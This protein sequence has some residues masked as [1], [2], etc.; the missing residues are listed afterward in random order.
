MNDLDPA[1]LSRFDQI[2][3]FP[4]PNDEERAA[5]FGNYARHLSAEECSHLSLKSA[6]LTGRNIKD[7]C[8]QAE[9]RWVR[10]ILAKSMEAAPPSFDYYRQSL[11][12]WKNSQ[13]Q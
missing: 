2:I 12:L 7:V 1:L 5:I 3:K 10:K 9:R 6:N 4:Y 8:E 11:Q 13:I